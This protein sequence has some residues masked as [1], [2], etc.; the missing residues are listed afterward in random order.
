M[1][2]DYYNYYYYEFVYDMQI[3]DWLRIKYRNLIGSKDI[4]NY[5]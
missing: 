3:N 5:K 2:K 4:I 1:D